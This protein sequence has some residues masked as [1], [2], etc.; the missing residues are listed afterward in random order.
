MKK[1]HLVLLVITAVLAVSSAYSLAL[2]NQ[3]HT[4]NFQWYSGFEECFT[5]RYRDITGDRYLASTFP[6]SA[7][8]CIIESR[9]E[10]ELA[11]E[12]YGKDFSRI[13]DIDYNRY[14]LIFITFGTVHSPEYRVRIA[15]IAQRG[16]TVEVKVS[17]ASPLENNRNPAS[18]VFKHTPFDAVRIDRSMFAGKGELKFVLKGQDGRQLFERHCSII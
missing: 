1:S 18:S 6:K 2:M 11:K 16:S 14:I 10:F 13:C 3:V 4:L 12:F 7:S 15:N 9:K 17:I 8:C 5:G